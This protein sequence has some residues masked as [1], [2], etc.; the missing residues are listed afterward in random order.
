MSFV[1]TRADVSAEYKA[2]FRH[3]LLTLIHEHGRSLTDMILWS[4]L[5]NMTA[6]SII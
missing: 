5:L 4:I 1:F 6:G 2:S 3:E